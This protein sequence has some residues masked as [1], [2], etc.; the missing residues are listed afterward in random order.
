MNLGATFQQT[1]A[2]KKKRHKIR[3]FHLKSVSRVPKTTDTNTPNR[4]TGV[5]NVSC[6]TEE[7]VTSGPSLHQDEQ[8]QTI[9]PFHI[10]QLGFEF[11][12]PVDQ[13]QFLGQGR[14]MRAR[15]AH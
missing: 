1:L 12:I 6:D 2:K 15:K 7:H 8:A 13:Q 4:L 9:I 5:A 3:S 11:S 10:I 14:P